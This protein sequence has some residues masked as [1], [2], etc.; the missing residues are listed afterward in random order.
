MPKFFSAIPI[1]F[2]SLFLILSAPS[3]LFAENYW[4]INDTMASLT[5]LLQGKSGKEVRTV[6]L[7]NFS[8]KHNC[9][10][11]VGL[12]MMNGQKLGSFKGGSEGYKGDLIIEIAGQEFTGKST[13]NEYTNG[14]EIV[15]HGK[16]SLLKAIEAH[17]EIA[18]LPWRA[19]IT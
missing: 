10:C 14:F 17:D 9:S 11:E 3:I 5:Q 2:I 15:M 19:N 13:I 16:D 8:T 12:I 7:V 6:F 4:K 18:L 1:L